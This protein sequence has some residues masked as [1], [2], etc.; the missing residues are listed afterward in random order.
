M[1][2]QLGSLQLELEVDRLDLHLGLIES[3]RL[4]EV[5]FAFLAGG[6]A[7][8][9]SWDRPGISSSVFRTGPL[10]IAAVLVVV[11]EVLR[12]LHPAQGANILSGAVEL[13]GAMTGIALS[14][15]VVPG[16]K[17]WRPSTRRSDNG[18]LSE[19]SP[20]GTVVS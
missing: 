8:A 1:Q 16:V 2:A 20:K 3:F 11:F 4:M 10:L 5:G 6:F 19:R 15:S 9:S 14:V 7:L 13:M 18:R 12:C 17:E